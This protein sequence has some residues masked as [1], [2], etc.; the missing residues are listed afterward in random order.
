MKY[1]KHIVVGIVAHIMATGLIFAGAMWLNSIET[2]SVDD[3]GV[4]E[5]TNTTPVSVS[6]DGVMLSWSHPI[7]NTSYIAVVSH[8]AAGTNLLDTGSSATSLG[9]V[10]W[11]AS[12]MYA[13]RVPVDGVIRI[14]SE[15]TNKFNIKVD[16]SRLQ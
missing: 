11:E 13:V 10:V 6:V 3:T 14:W 8:S 2:T 16:V 1:W 5:W 12:S 9:S 15:A 7:P 4:Y